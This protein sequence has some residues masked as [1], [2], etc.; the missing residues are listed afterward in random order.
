MF[1]EGIHWYICTFADRSQYHAWALM[2]L[3]SDLANGLQILKASGM[4]VPAVT[5]LAR[6][7]G[8]V[9]AIRT[10]P[11]SDHPEFLLLESLLTLA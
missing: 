7:Q 4:R 9:K 10:L 11:R 3:W 1:L 8:R 6:R 2:S 5:R